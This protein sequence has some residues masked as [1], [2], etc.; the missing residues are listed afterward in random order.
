MNL[1]SFMPRVFIPRVAIN[2]RQSSTIVHN[3]DFCSKYACS[4][5][6]ILPE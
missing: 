5:Q 3:L 4:I 2:I 6:N 1:F